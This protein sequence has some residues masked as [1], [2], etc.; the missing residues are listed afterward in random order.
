MDEL[1]HC[2]QVS[3]VI[4]RGYAKV[5]SARR[6]TPTEL[7]IAL[8]QGYHAIDSDLALPEVRAHVERQ[9]NLVAQGKAKK[10][11]VV[12]HTLAQ[13]EQ[14]F[15][16]FTANIASMDKLFEASFAPLSSS[17]KAFTR[18]GSCL[19]Y[20][21]LI[22][23]KPQ[24]LYCPN[25]ERV[26]DLPQGGQIK[27]Y[28]GLSCPLCSFELLMISIGE[29]TFPLCPNCFASPPYPSH[30][31]PPKGTILH[32]PHPPSH[33]IVDQVAVGPCPECDKGQ[34]LI[35]P[36]ASGQR[37]K[38]CC[39]SCRIT[40][41]ITER[42]HKLT[43]SRQKP[44]A[45]CG[46]RLLRLEFHRE[47]GRDNLV[48]CVHCNESIVELAQLKHSAGPRAPHRGRGKGRRG[49]RGGRGRGRHIDPKMSFEGF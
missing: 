48:G 46:S 10:D 42:L 35:D 7:G 24:R 49:K 29:R 15:R 45:D 40:V 1:S 16:Y 47:V 33:P 3:N 39:T 34:L 22:N 19:R 30:P 8:V 4:E 23:T 44:C 26:L 11:T 37:R 18:C 9:L 32:C 25:E 14:K 13:F 27:P 38:L 5:D 36:S 28:L 43:I 21:K 12:Q 6:I 41:E 20:L 31:S 17:G 2:V